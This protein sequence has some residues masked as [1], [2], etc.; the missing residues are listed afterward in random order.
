MISER[1]GSRFPRAHGSPIHIGDPKAIGI[2]NIDRPDF[3]DAV[4]ILP[5]EVPVFWACGVTPQAVVM[6]VKPPVVFTHKPGYMFV[7]DWRDTDLE[8]EST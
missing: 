2:E 4:Q 8:G 7:T 3:G 5:G 1:I 6:A